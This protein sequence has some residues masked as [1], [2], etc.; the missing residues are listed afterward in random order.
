M[1]KRTFLLR[2]LNE[3]NRVEQ[4]VW[5]DN[6]TA[7]VLDQDEPERVWDTVRREDGYYVLTPE[8]GVVKIV[9]S[10]GDRPLFR[11]RER[12][13]LRS[14]DLENYPDTPETQDTLITT[15]GNVITNHLV[16]CIPFGDE[17]PFQAGRIDIRAIEDIIEDRL[18]SDPE[19]D[20]GVSRSPK[21]VI[22]TRE[23][24]KYR[25]YFLSMVGYNANNVQSTT[26]KSLTGHPDRKKRRAELLEQYK[27]QLTDPA[28]IARIEGEMVALDKEWLEG[29]PSLTFYSVHDKYFGKV[30]K[31]LYS[32]FGGEAPFSDGVVMTLIERSLEEGIDPND[33]P[34]MINSLREGTYNRGAQTQLGGE[35]TKTIYR[36]LGTSR[37][38]G[39]DCGVRYGVPFNFTPHNSKDFVNY[40][41]IIGGK[42]TLL[43]ESQ[44]KSLEGTTV[45][46]RSPL[47]CRAGRDDGGRNVCE[48][49]A[50]TDLSE[51]KD[52]I[53]ATGAQI[54]GRFLSA[55]LAA[56]HG[57][58]LATH[59][60]DLD[61]RIR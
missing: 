29:D 43:T 23:Y 12:F 15:V 13:D 56:M 14:G 49:C 31:R 20:D 52:G 5:V 1:D 60:L 59:R 3:G 27:D 39:E 8:E 40:W 19:D 45:E 6:I 38:V 48:R 25:D 11:W 9:D 7:M 16:L 26:P 4:K 54:G 61:L 53:P 41:A 51:I 55:F 34:L 17:I 22:Y 10:S 33:L 28:I 42:D 30:R 35:S 37:I 2:A 57:K 21:G 32:M 50:G 18:Q 44:V 24:R 47:T 58:T 36:M 46:V